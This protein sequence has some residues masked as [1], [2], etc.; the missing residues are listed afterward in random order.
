VP[1]FRFFVQLFTWGRGSLAFICLVGIALLMR[2]GTIEHKQT[3]VDTLLSTLFFPAQSLIS[4]V[5]SVKNLDQENHYLKNENARLRLEND[6]LIQAKSE[7]VR[8]RKMVGF[9]SPWAYPVSLAQVVGRNPGQ[10]FTTL[11]I[12]RGYKDSVSKDM[13]V[14][15][16]KGLVGKV[17]KVFDGHAMVQLLADPNLKV[18][19]ISQRTRT[20]GILESK[21]GER[22]MAMMPSHADIQP[23]DTLVTSGLGGVFPKGIQVGILT[24]IQSDDIEVVRYCNVR[25]LQNP[26]LLEELFVIHK[27][28]DW[29]VR[30]LVP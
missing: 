14:F 22:L 25:Q 27:E 2:N 9:E 15:T 5:T 10:Y 16:S 6:L 23:G 30:G 3:I 29:V 7:T 17:S 12:N 21:D 19:V 18:S 13:P 28:P 26:A 1:L 11:V 20:V 8:L 24:G 4:V